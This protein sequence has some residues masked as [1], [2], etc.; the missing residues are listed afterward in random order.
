[1]AEIFPTPSAARDAMI[2]AGWEVVDADDYIDA[3]EHPDYRGVLAALVA[4]THD[5][6]EGCAPALVKVTRVGTGLLLVGYVTGREVQNWARASPSDPDSPP[7]LMWTDAEVEVIDPGD[8]RAQ[9][10]VHDGMPADPFGDD[11]ASA[12]HA[13]DAIELFAIMGTYEAAGFTRDEAFK[14]VES[15][16]QVELDHAAQ[17]CLVEHQHHREQDGDQ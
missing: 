14:L 8:P 10:R 3:H 16:H 12:A 2:A 15:I 11:P 6:E 1:M 9:D 7:L 5:G 13:T 4:T 17:H